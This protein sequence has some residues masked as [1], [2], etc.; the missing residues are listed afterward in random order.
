MQVNDKAGLDQAGTQILHP[1]CRTLFRHWE[2]IRAERACPNRDDIHLRHIS[3]IVPDLVI[4]EKNLLKSGWQY[5]LAGTRVC[6]LFQCELTGKDALSG[7]DDFERN[8]VTESLEVS[9]TQL[10]P[11]LVRMRFINERGTVIAAEMIGLPI[12]ATKGGSIQ[13]LGGLFPFV[14][15]SQL[16]P[17]ALV[18][19]EL[20]SARTIWTE[21]GQN[22]TILGNIGRKT[23]FEP[24]VIQGGLV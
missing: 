10:Q 17:A 13:I 19:R 5:R 11:C 23:R 4:L 18:R 20:V 6:D 12:T 3:E 7:W 14:D 16:P 1:G 21:H 2:A 9:L 15:I 8:V 22:E 24:R